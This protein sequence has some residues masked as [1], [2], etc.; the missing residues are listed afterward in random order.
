LLLDQNSV[1]R[2][3][4]VRLPVT[5]EFAVKLKNAITLEERLSDHRA[6]W[7]LLSREIRGRV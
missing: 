4:V 2:V 6:R 7:N 5:E 3:K 1:S